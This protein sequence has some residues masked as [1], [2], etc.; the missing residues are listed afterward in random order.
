M[1]AFFD[2]KTKKHSTMK[3]PLN[4]IQDTNFWHYSLQLSTYA[5]M[6]QKIDPRFEIKAL[7]LLHYDHDGGNATYECEYLKSDVE[8]MLAFHKKTIEHDEFK[9]SREKIIF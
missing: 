1:K 3:Y 4:N 6:I 7:I 8:R 5:W 9:R 2:R